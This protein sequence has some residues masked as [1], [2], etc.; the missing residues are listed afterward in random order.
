MTNVSLLS[1]YLFVTIELFITNKIAAK[2]NLTD[3]P[4]P[5]DIYAKT[6]ES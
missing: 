4:T 2:I 3:S 1:D 5:D 6:D